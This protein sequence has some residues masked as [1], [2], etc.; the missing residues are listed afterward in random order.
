MSG[1]RRLCIF[2]GAADGLPAEYREAARAFGAAAARRGI[3][4]VYGGCSTGLMGAM[5]DGALDLGGEVIGVLPDVLGGREPGHPRLTELLRVPDMH[6]RKAMM[7]ALVDGF[8]ALPGG[9]GTLDELFEALTWR[10]IGTHAKPIALLDVDDY[11]APL[12]TFIDQA[13]R[14]GFVAERARRFFFV[15]QDAERLLDEL[16]RIIG[17]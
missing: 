7:T 13:A 10:Q 15:E 14:T 1:K 17:A 2:C 16:A 9:Y 6:T 12:I 4:L 3:G 8:V 11:F 5:A